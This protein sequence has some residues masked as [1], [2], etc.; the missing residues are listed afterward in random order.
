MRW[1]RRLTMLRLLVLAGWAMVLVEL[2]RDPTNVV[3]RA[4]LSAAVVVTVIRWYV[5]D[6]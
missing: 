6:E 4:L 1:P 2:W 3:I 5:E